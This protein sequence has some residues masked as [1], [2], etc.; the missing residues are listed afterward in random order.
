MFALKSTNLQLV[1]LIAYAIAK[2]ETLKFIISCP[3]LGESSADDIF[4]CIFLNENAFISFKI[5][6]EFV[7]KV[8]INNIPALV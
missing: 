8:R 7:P 2:N 4:K 1:C 5:S 3:V 6:M